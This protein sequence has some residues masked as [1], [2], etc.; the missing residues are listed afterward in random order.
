MEKDS[1]II[2]SGWHIYNWYE[3]TKYCGRCGHILNHKETERAKICSNCGT[4]YYPQIAP[5]II[6]AISYSNKLLLTKYANNKKARYALVA[7]FIEVGETP[8]DAVR[9]EV[10][11]EVGLKVKNIKYYASQ[12]WGIT[13]GLLLGYTAMLDGDSNITLDLSE[14]SEGTWMTK[15]EIEK[16]DISNK[17]LTGTLINEWVKNN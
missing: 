9:R 16:L 3:N 14:L 1:Y 4:V 12:P 8:E 6:V 5:A 13:G 2:L 7:G 17:T 11:E 10:A 15:N